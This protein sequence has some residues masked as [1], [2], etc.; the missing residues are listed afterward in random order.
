MNNREREIFFEA[1][2]IA[3]PGERV[4]FV[5]RACAGDV[6]LR[7]RMR[8]L[9]AAHEQAGSFLPDADPLLIDFWVKVLAKENKKL[10][11][12]AWAEQ[13][14]Q[15]YPQFYSDLKPLP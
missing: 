2:E 3:A 7:E 11:W 8:A 14:L 15:K 12:P 10:D 1:M 4:S 5:E 13:V 6:S 9:L